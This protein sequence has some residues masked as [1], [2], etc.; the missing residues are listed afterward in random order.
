MLCKKVV[1]FFSLLSHTHEQGARKM[2]ITQELLSLVT[3]LAHY[4]K[5]LIRIALTAALKLE[6]EYD[7]KLAIGHFLSKLDRLA[8]DP[9]AH[10]IGGSAANAGALASSPTA[11]EGANG[12]HPASANGH[13]RSE[14]RSLSPR[15]YGYKSLT[16]AIGSTLIGQGE[17][18]TD[19]CEA[20]HLTVEEECA[21]FGT[22]V[23]WH[24]ACLKCGSCG[25]VASKDAPATAE[26]E[27]EYVWLKEF[28]V[29][30]SGSPSANTSMNGRH[31]VGSWTTICSS[32]AADSARDGFDYVTRL[33]Q[34]AFLL[35][36]ALN[37]L[38]A[39]LKQRG[40]VPPSPGT[41]ADR[42]FD[43]GGRADGSPCRRGRRQRR[44]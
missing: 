17:A 13:T 43:L 16:R 10:K 31:K 19:L 37:K 7:N 23:R 28:R 12:S 3:G 20:C 32:C 14:T 4:L 5:I 27:R 22:S 38:Y 44:L 33:E 41:R 25:K 42:I 21:R 8:R 18:T 15:T 35:C 30:A 9:E 34:Y 29:D 36:V 2:S 24:L 39:L 26:E 6:R 1:N 11:I 40:V